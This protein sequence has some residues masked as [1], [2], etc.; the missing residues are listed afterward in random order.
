MIIGVRPR[1]KGEEMH[2]AG[3]KIRSE[4]MTIHALEKGKLA[5]FPFAIPQ[6]D[7]ERGSEQASGNSRDD[8]G[9]R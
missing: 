5:E 9:I 2:E 3:T 8:F 1:V 4:A 7:E 6:F